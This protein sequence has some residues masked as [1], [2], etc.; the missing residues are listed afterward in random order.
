MLWKVACGSDMSVASSVRSDVWTWE[1]HKERYRIHG[2]STWVERT[3]FAQW[4]RYVTLHIAST[5]HSE[6]IYLF[7]S[8]NTNNSYKKTP[9][10]S[11]FLFSILTS[12]SLRSSIS[13]TSSHDSS[14]RQPQPFFLFPSLAATLPLL[15]NCFA[16]AFAFACPLSHTPSPRF[17]W[18]R[19]TVLTDQSA[20]KHRLDR[21]PSSS[22]FFPCFFCLLIVYSTNLYISK[23]ILSF[24]LIMHSSQENF[25]LLKKV[26]ISGKK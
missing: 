5:L 10:S 18:C 16:F 2:E 14:N 17:S 13:R 3:H 6:P 8:T 9:P 22:K 12:V 26:V 20:F 23:R 19:L 1:D 24:D 21:V 4:P 25:V 7:P 11:L 15:L